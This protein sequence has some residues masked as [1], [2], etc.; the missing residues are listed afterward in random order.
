M[1]RAFLKIV[2]PI[3]SIFCFRM[4]GLFMLIPVFT[5]YADELT[6]STPF[7]IGLAFG[8]YGLTQCLLQIPFGLLSD[9][10]GR[11]KVLYIGLLLFLIGSVIGAVA[12][13]IEMMIVARAIQ[14]CGAI[15]STLIALIADLTDEDSRTKAMAFLGMSIGISFSVAMVI[16]P[17][18]ARFF[19]LPGI[20]W[21]TA[22]LCL[23]GFVILH[24]FIPNPVKEVRHMECETVPSL[25]K[26]VMTNP[27]LVKLDC[28]IFFQHAILTSTF[29]LIPMILENKLT[30]YWVFYLPILIASF[31]CMIPLIL[32]AETKKKMKPIFVYAILMTLIPQIALFFFH[33][34]LF[35]IGLYLFV[36]FIA[37]NVLEASLPSLISKTSPIHSKGTAMGVYSSAQFLGIFVGGLLAGSLYHHFGKEG[38]FLGNILLASIWL[39]IAISMSQPKHLT[40][41]IVHYEND[42]EKTHLI[43]SQLLAIPGIKEVTVSIS[44]NLLYL[45]YDK[46]ELHSNSLNAI[47]NKL[48]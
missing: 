28:G 41:K 8:I 2:T 12:K 35:T 31:L 29:Y 18:I 20:F 47:I 21:L 10:I 30:V 42:K 22:C 32:Y 1:Q 46:N 45:K 40:T 16:S 9:K 14:G 13:S 26:S 37:F 25:L 27:E 43:K 44:E 48:A 39:L 11:K 5:I 3:A 17:I 33:N 6:G 24:W 38:I 15:G 36:Y 34:E 19:H 4:L 23:L 7:L